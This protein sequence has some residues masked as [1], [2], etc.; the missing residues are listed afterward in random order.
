MGEQSRL[1]TWPDVN[2]LN[3]CPLEPKLASDLQVLHWLNSRFL[4]KVHNTKTGTKYKTVPCMLNSTQRKGSILALPALN[5][6]ARNGCL[7][8]ATPWLLYARE[9]NATHCKARTVGFRDGLDSSEKI[10]T[11]L[12]FELWNTQTSSGS[13]CQQWCP[14]KIK[15]S[16]TYGKWCHWTR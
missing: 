4:H 16:I 1:S 5:P 12:G 3:T 11:S 7:I 10:C 13:L 8:S 6:V 15:A 14:S 9:R 2:V